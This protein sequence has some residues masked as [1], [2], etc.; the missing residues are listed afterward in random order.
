MCS[1]GAIGDDE[2]ECREGEG[3][4]IG[5]PTDWGTSPMSKSSASVA[6]SASPLT[7]SPVC[8]GARPTPVISSLI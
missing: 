6:S 4:E 8:L 7:T 1:S 3:I 5:K 2:E